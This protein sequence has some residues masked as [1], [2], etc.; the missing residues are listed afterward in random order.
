MNPEQLKR[1]MGKEKKGGYGVQNVSDK[2][3]LYYGDDF[4]VT[5]ES[6][7]GKGTRVTIEIPAV[8]PVS[9]GENGDSAI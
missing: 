8:P 1:L 4:G 7:P 2:I 6:E 3:K 9:D 5:Y